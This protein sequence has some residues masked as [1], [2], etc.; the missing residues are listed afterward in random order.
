MWLVRLKRSKVELQALQRG[1]GRQTVTLGCL[2]TLR[3]PFAL[4][5]W[6]RVT[7]WVI[8]TVKCRFL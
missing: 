1:R 7:V 2:V 6:G 5:S 3:C 4:L 8:K